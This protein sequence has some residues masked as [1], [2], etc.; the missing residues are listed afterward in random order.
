MSVELERRGLPTAMISA[1]PPVARELGANRVVRG[2]KI[3][4]P[5]GDPT[6]EPEADRALRQRIVCAALDSLTHAIDRSTIFE[7]A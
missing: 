5:C 6:L 3:P 7:P 4:H 2:V 1:L